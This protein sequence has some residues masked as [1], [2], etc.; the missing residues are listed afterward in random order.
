MVI[1][2]EFMKLIYLRHPQ[3]MWG[4][5]HNDQ[6]WHVPLI[7]QIIGEVSVFHFSIGLLSRGM[8]YIICVCP[9]WASGIEDTKLFQ[10]VEVPYR[11]V[12]EAC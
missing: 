10:R 1:L 6:I 11:R 7:F 2:V 5:R 12:G 4:M 9:V 3:L 8:C